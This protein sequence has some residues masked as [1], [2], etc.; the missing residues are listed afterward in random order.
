MPTRFFSVICSGW[1]VCCPRGVCDGIGGK[2]LVI[3]EPVSGLMGFCSD[4]ARFLSKLFKGRASEAGKVLR[5]LHTSEHWVQRSRLP[6][7]RTQ[8]VL[9]SQGFI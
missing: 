9:L 6:L 2:A 3:I 7:P 8:D 4:F 5:L 1:R